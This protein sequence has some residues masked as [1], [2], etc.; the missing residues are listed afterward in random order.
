MKDF[1]KSFYYI[2]IMIPKE[3][4]T[5]HWIYFFTLFVNVKAWFKGSKERHY[6]NVT[7]IIRDEKGEIK[8]IL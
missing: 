4:I 1:L 5:L 3:I 8:E 2:F 6:L 7:L